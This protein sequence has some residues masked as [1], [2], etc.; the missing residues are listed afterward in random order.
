MVSLDFDVCIQGEYLVSTQ[1]YGAFQGL[2][3]EERTRCVGG[4]ARCFLNKNQVDVFVVGDTGGISLDVSHEIGTYHSTRA[5]ERLAAD[6]SEMAETYNPDFFLTL[7]DNIYWNGVDDKFDK[8]F[9]VSK[10]PSSS[11]HVVFRLYLKF[12]IWMGDCYD[13]GI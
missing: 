3:Y 5:Q 7:G 2:T 1:S 12:H 10:K 6:M 11:K 4:R 13:H 8:R 9:E